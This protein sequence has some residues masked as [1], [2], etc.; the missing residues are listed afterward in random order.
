MTHIISK[1]SLRQS[2][3]ILKAGNPLLCP[4]DTV[5]GLAAD[6]LCDRAIEK[7]YD[8]KN[9][10]INKSFVVVF[11]SLE[12]AQIY[13]HFNDTALSLAKSFWPGPLTLIVPKKQPISSV[14]MTQNT[15]AMRIPDVPYIQ[16]I[17]QQLDRPLV[18]TSANISGEAA[19]H[20]YD[21]VSQ[22]IK[23]KLSTPI[24][25]DLQNKWPRPSTIF[26]TINQ[27]ILRQ[28]DINEKTLEKHL[29]G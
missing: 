21:K 28:G 19:V 18:L 10:P 7:L 5:W 29:T 14:F 4:T 8:I 11:D 9:R 2:I 13:G 1:A 12:R 25:H 17:I 22:S 15:Y 3:D 6:A 26:D 16:K 27:S 23:L 20:Q 24:Q